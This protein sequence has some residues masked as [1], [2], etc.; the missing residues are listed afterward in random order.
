MDSGMTT[1]QWC[2]KNN[3]SEN[4]YYYWLKV[5]RR[6]MPAQHAENTLVTENIRTQGF[7]ELPSAVVQAAAEPTGR[8]GVLAAVLRRGNICIELYAD[9]PQ[10]LIETL[11]GGL[12][13][14]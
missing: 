9:T 11:I 10:P 6:E 5:I 4:S 1:A 7:V 13:H 3:I 14:A 2:C 12:A 8:S